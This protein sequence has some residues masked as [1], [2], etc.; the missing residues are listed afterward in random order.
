MSIYNNAKFQSKYCYGNDIS[1]F[2]N[3][4]TNTDTL[5]LYDNKSDTRTE[6]CRYGFWNKG[7]I[8]IFDSS[9][10]SSI[11]LHTNKKIYAISKN[12]LP[13]TEVARDREYKLYTILKD[14][15]K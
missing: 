1:I 3:Y 4:N 15:S 12:S 8:K 2:L 5:Y 6:I 11:N 14:F 10:L 9:N 7:D 13:Y